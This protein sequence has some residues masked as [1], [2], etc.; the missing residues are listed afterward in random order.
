[1]TWIHGMLRGASA[2]TC[3]LVLAC[4]ENTRSPSGPA[5]LALGPG[6]TEAVLPEFRIANT[7]GL[8]EHSFSAAYDG[9]NYLVVGQ[10][11]GIIKA[12]LVHPDKSLSPQISANHYGY[13]PYVA[14]DG[15]NYLLA[16]ADDGNLNVMGQFISPAGAKVGTPFK[17]TA[18]GDVAFLRGLAYANGQ[19]CF[20]FVRNDAAMYRRLM[21]P[22]KSFSSVK[23]ISG[24]Y[25]IVPFQ[26]HSNL[27]TDGTNFLAVYSAGSAGF[28][29]TVAA[30]LLRSD[31]TLGTE[32]T[33]SDIGTVTYLDVTATFA[34]GK[35]F[36]VW[37][38]LTPTTTSYTG[39]VYGRLLTTTGATSGNRINIASSARF[40]IAMGVTASN[41]NFEVLFHDAADDN[42]NASVKGRFYDASGTALTTA[43]K[44]F[45]VKNG[46][47]PVLGAALATGSSF[48]FVLNRPTPYIASTPL[49]YFTYLDSNVFGSFATLGP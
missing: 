4:G 12:R 46:T 5:E 43:A 13:I 16:W 42:V 22:A 18:S 40:E 33:V 24:V 1:M 34:N 48:F 36:V 32:R 29:T 6:Q 37:T 2:A 19:Y 9:T 31:G 14:F 3:G 49:Y 27:A 45:G 17:M 28:P 47:I 20:T 44:L 23:V 21:T 25:S 7:F 8:E 26:Y 10:Y 30:R 35:Y 39:D 38:D 15:T 11:D 41:G